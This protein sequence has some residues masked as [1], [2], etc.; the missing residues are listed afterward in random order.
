MSNRYQ[1]WYKPPMDPALVFD[2]E[3]MK[4]IEGVSKQN[5]NSVEGYA[6]SSTCQPYL[7]PISSRPKNITCV[8]W[9]KENCSNFHSYE[10]GLFCSSGRF[11]LNACDF[12]IWRFW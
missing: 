7:T 6:R 10:L 8:N 12:L 1:G 9:V 5:P 4:A 3:A 11:S 2:F